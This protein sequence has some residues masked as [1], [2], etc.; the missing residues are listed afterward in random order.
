MRRQ[1]AKRGDT[2]IREFFAWFPKFT[3]TEYR[4]LER[5]RVREEYGFIN[6]AVLDQWFI[7]EFLDNE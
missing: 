1:F 3:D 6:G 7:A 5:V 4:W 2:R